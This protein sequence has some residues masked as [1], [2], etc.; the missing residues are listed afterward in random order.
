MDAGYHVIDRYGRTRKIFEE[1]ERS[2]LF[3]FFS[4][5]RSRCEMPEM[6]Q[7]TSRLTKSAS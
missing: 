2:K 6:A 1:K 7:T 5:K 3:L 4:W